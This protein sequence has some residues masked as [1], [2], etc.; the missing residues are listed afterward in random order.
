MLRFRNTLS[1]RVEEF[2]PLKDGEVSFY[3]CGPT[4][5]NYGHIGNFRSA[6]AADVV[7]RYLKFKGFEVTHVM[8]MTDVDDRII[9]E[10]QKAGLTIDDYTAKYIDAFWEDFDA[11]GCERPEVVPRA[12]HHIPEM[13]RSSTT[14]IA[15]GHAYRSDGLDLL[16]HRGV[17]DTASC[18]RSTS[19]ATS[20]AAANESTRTSTRRK[21]RAT[22]RFGKGLRVEDEPAG[23]LRSV[24]A[25]RAGTSSARRCR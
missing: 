21:T 2:R 10:S 1:G 22:S 16:P 13:I 5:W 7:R 15:H 14:L 19:R 25:V 6:V 12:T 9:T 23:T 20:P 11:L 24:A 8:N 18:R 3:Y 4:V 17:S